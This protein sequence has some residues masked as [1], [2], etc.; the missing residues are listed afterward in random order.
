MLPV[1][2]LPPGAPP[3]LRVRFVAKGTKMG[4]SNVEWRLEGPADAEGFVPTT[5]G[6]GD[7]NRLSTLPPLAVLQWATTPLRI[8]GAEAE[9]PRPPLPA[10]GET[11]DVDVPIDGRSVRISGTL[12]DAAGRPV[13]PGGVLV[14]TDHAFPGKGVGG[15]Y[16]A[17]GY[18]VAVGARGEFVLEIPGLRTPGPDDEPDKLVVIAIAAGYEVSR[19]ELPVADADDVAIKMHPDTKH[20]SLDL[21]VRGVDG[22]PAAG[23]RLWIRSVGSKIDLRIALPG[24]HAPDDEIQ[25]QAL[26]RFLGGGRASEQGYDV[27]QDRNPVLNLST[28]A[29]GRLRLE[30][31]P[32]GTYRVQAVNGTTKDAE[33]VGADGWLDDGGGGGWQDGH[34]VDAAEVAES[35]ITVAPWPGRTT[36]TIRLD[37]ARTVVGRIVADRPKDWCDP[38]E[39]FNHLVDLAE[40]PWIHAEVESGHWEMSDDV[41]RFDGRF[42]LTGLPLGATRLGVC[43]SGRPYVSVDV[44]AATGSGPLDLGDIHVPGGRSLRG[45]VT[46]EDGTAIGE[47]KVGRITLLDGEREDTY[48][49]VN[50]GSY[51]S[52]LLR[53]PPRPG[54]VLVIDFGAVVAPPVRV[55]LAPTKDED[56][57]LHQ[58]VRIRK[59]AP[60]APDAAPNADGS[61]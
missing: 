12:R 28:D 44:P 4:L 7:A 45:Q 22:R 23:V 16:D 8:S 18:G 1:A 24:D 5:H 29:D 25:E 52:L 14:R 15:A 36:A 50:G 60:A 27:A 55:P 41:H 42:R 34:H 13:S 49:Y 3:P 21:L 17:G 31:L 9:I 56:G 57:R 59:P 35:T 61:K 30:C 39:H 37:A 2:P 26:A 58:D 51:D 32:A 38:G 19:S 6:D 54:D 46:W 33:P 20:G 43:T 53:R 11:L 10:E 47:A 48:Q 40:W